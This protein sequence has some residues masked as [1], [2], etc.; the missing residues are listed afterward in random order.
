MAMVVGAELGG[1]GETRQAILQ[2][3]NKPKLLDKHMNRPPFAFLHAVIKNIILNTGYQ[4]HLFTKDELNSSTIK[5]KAAKVEWLQK[6][7]DAGASLQLNWATLF[8]VDR[9]WM[10][11][12]IVFCCALISLA[13]CLLWC[14]WFCTAVVLWFL[15]C[16]VAVSP[17]TDAGFFLCDVVSF[18]Q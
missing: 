11:V 7:K 13:V 10:A 12:S 9:V 2:F 17:C 5:N 18:S 8:T 3:T 4:K 16:L 6:I 15:P 1:V 14:L